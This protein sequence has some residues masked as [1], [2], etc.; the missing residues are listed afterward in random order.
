MENKMKTKMKSMLTVLALGASAF[1]ASAQ[2]NN[3]P[4]NNSSNDWQRPRHRPPPLPIVQ[5]LDVNHDGVIDADEIANAPAELK[6]LD[7]NGDGV[8]TASEYL[9]PLPPDAP[10]DAPRPPLPPIIKALDVNG[11]GVIDAD[12]IA[13]APAELKTL[14]KNGDG[15]L[16]RDEICPPRPAGPDGQVNN[17][18]G[19]DNMPPGPPPGDDDGNNPPPGP[20][21]GD[22]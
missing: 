14:D 4:W 7:K 10:A 8:L 6:T 15:V 13:N 9:P 12:E 21:P 20:P 5:A 11:D 2:D 17:Y 22:Q 19:G 1:A 16:T 3:Q 18:G